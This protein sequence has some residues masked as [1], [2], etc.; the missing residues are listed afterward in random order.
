MFG[1]ILA[2]SESQLLCMNSLISVVNNA[3]NPKTGNRSEDILKNNLLDLLK[4]DSK[5]TR[6]HSKSGI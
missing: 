5:E 2:I 3:T 4:K 1:I 6:K